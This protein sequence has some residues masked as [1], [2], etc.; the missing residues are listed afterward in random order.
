MS[1]ERRLKELG[2]EHLANDPQKLQAALDQKARELDS[3]LSR[4]QTER[5]RQSQPVMQD[6]RQK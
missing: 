2:L 3:R 4:P 1:R 5:R 6:R